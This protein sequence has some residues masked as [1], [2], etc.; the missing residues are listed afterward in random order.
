[1]RERV[2]FAA[3]ARAVLNES[4]RVVVEVGPGNALSGLMRQ[5][6]QGNGAAPLLVSLLGGKEVEH[7]YEQVLRGV[8]Q[9]WLEGVGVKWEEMWRGERRRRVKLPTYPFE[10]VRC[11][12]DVNKVSRALPVHTGK[13]PD[14]ANW[15][16][17]PSWKRSTLA[18]L[19]TEEPR[20][21]WLVFTSKNE[22]GSEVVKHLQEQG[23]EVISVL[24]GKRF[25]EL[26]DGI[27]KI[28]PQ[29]REDYSAFVKELG[30]LPR[31]PQRV[32]HL[33]SL[34]T[35]PKSHKNFEKAQAQGFH[36]LLLLAQALDEFK[37][38]HKLDLTV[39]SDSVQEVTGDELLQPEKATV[40]GPSRILPQEYPNITYR[41]IDVVL[42]K[43]KRP[44]HDLVKR[45]DPGDHG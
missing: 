6:A 11:W 4:G 18:R 7:E 17:A 34:N 19:R 10:R 24:C 2:R 20:N 14:I 27:Y 29:R 28:D 45:T 23:D 32:V 15:F 1:M 16:Y 30:T 3:G 9:L 36:S 40:L 5:Q 44:Q 37:V 43:S 22:F 41:S 26:G 38:K 33:W 21:C 12:V 8:A 42:P 13:Q 35:I 25:A 39:V 31:P